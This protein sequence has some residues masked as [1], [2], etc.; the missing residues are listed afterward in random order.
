[1][2]YVELEHFIFFILT[3]PWLGVNGRRP[4]PPPG[5]LCLA[6]LNDDKDGFN[7]G[8]NDCILIRMFLVVDCLLHFIL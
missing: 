3:K 8:S 4:G 5:S 2:R 1:M 7:N 6:N